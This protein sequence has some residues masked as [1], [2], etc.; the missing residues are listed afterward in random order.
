MDDE[1][2]SPQPAGDTANGGGL[3]LLVAPPKVRIRAETD[4][5]FYRRKQSTVVVRHVSGDRMVAVVEIVS[6]GNT[7]GQKAFRMFLDE[8]PPLASRAPAGEVKS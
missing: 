6:P 4:M 2:A 7:S 8:A 3:G 5:E 1:P